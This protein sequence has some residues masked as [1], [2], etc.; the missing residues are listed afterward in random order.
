MKRFVIPAA[1]FILPFFICGQVLPP[2]V[3]P[4]G[5]FRN[6]GKDASSFIQL[7]DGSGLKRYYRTGDV[8]M[9]DPEGDLLYI[10]RLDN[11]VQIQGF[12]VEMGEIE[13]IARTYPGIGQ[14]AAVAIP[15]DV[16]NMQVILVLENFKNENDAVRDFLKEKLPNYM[17]PSKILNIN[18]LPKTLGGKIDR[19]SIMEFAKL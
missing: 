2:D 9:R 11:Q 10:G 1:F 16:G 8:V 15:N 18:E 3:Y 19:K 7:N 6:P 12:R 17:W 4:Q 5:Y 13:A 14:L